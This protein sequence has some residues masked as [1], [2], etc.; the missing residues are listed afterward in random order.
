MELGGFF[1]IRL[2]SDGGQFGEPTKY[3]ETKLVFAVMVGDFYGDGN[4]DLIVY[5]HIQ[6]LSCWATAQGSSTRTRNMKW[7]VLITIIQ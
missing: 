5:S 6:F 7:S 3:S 2:G 4:Q 1:Y